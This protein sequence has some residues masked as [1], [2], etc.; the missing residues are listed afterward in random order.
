[1]KTSEE[2][3]RSIM[4]RAKA[5]RAA[6]KRNVITFA[7][8][9]VCVCGIGAGA[10]MLDR[11]P[12]QPV[13]TLQMQPTAAVQTPQE[14]PTVPTEPSA[15]NQVTNIEL[16]PVRISL[17]SSLSSG[18]NGVAIG[19]GV[20]V[21]GQQMIRVVDIRKLTKEQAEAVRAGEAEFADYFLDQSY[22]K[23][24]SHMI[25]GENAIVTVLSAGCLYIPIED[26]DLVESVRVSVTG[27]GRM[28]SLDAIK[29][30]QTGQIIPGEY[31]LEGW[32][33]KNEWRNYKGVNMI[34]MLTEEMHQKLASD[35]TIALSSI[36]STIT[37]KVNMKDGTTASVLVDVTIEDNGMVYFTFG[38]EEGKVLIPWMQQ[39]RVTDL[40]KLTDDQ[41]QAIRKGEREYA[42][43]VA[44]H[45]GIY[46]MMNGKNAVVTVVS[47]GDLKIPV[48]NPDL[49]DNVRVSVTGHGIINGPLSMKIEDN[50]DRVIKGC[51]LRENQGV[52]M[53]WMLT[54]EMLRKLA[55]DPTIPLSSISSTI[56]ATINMK[57]GTQKSVIVDVSVDDDGMVYFT[58]RG[59]TAT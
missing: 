48:K 20:R 6:Q 13:D 37:V 31:I 51:D 17:L 49:V 44:Q 29:D 24:A 4:G 55:A 14:V 23:A 53:N 56:T 32:N 57:D 21:P 7:V 18:G 38:G 39:I 26:P 54:E 28:E 11:T 5:K 9:C 22:S 46:L 35:P 33:L 36:T 45:Q 10:W 30:V 1:M 43:Y 19:N 12:V 27:D 16:R 41:A 2:M 59:E 3:A 34:W 25:F 15:P 47:A 42:D 50:G 58:S 52:K 40:R 8:V